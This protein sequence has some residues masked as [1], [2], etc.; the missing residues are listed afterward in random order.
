MKSKKEKL[1]EF[2]LSWKLL[3]ELP[4]TVQEEEKHGGLRRGKLRGWDCGDLK[5]EDDKMMGDTE[6]GPRRRSENGI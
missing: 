5:G 2:K 1:R 4:D 3:E 6:Q